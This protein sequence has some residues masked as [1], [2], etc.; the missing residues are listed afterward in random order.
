M[1]GIIGDPLRFSRHSRTPHRT[2]RRL[3]AAKHRTLFRL[4]L[5]HSMISRQAGDFFFLSFISACAL[6]DSASTSCYIPIPSL[7]SQLDKDIDIGII[8]ITTIVTM[9]ITIIKIVMLLI[10]IVI[11]NDNNINNLIALFS[12]KKIIKI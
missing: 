9:I 6:K 7:S 10:M 4:R 1:D 5:A 11:H 2:L 8:V 3:T 12:Y